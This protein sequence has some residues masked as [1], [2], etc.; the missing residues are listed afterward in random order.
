MAFSSPLVVS[1]TADRPRMAEMT[2]SM[3]HRLLLVEAHV[4]EPVVDMAAVRAP[5]GS[6]PWRCRRIKAKAG[7]EDG[8]AQ[9]EKG[10]QQRR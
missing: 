10:H 1:T 5:W 2:Y 3:R 4:D 6:A 9:D 7:V 8:Q